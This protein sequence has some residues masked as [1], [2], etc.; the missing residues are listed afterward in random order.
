MCS[1]DMCSKLNDGQLELLNFI[2]KHAIECKLATKNGLDKP[3]PGLGK[4]TLVKLKDFKN[5]PSVLVTTLTRKTT[6]DT[7][8]TTVNSAYKL[9]IHSKRRLKKYIQKV[10]RSYAD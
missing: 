8:G 1:N 2:S 5:E 6:T 7:D 3:D 4:S 9:P 10:R